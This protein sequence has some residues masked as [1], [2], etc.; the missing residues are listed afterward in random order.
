MTVKVVG[1]REFHLP[2]Q[3][4]ERRKVEKEMMAWERKVRYGDK[5]RDGLSPLIPKVTNKRKSEI[6]IPIQLDSRTI[7]RVRESK[8]FKD[9]WI[10]RFGSR[11]VLESYVKKYKELNNLN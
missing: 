7:V 4:R 2:T 5:A 3:Y 11:E 1:G 10:K 6:E 9:K 8:I